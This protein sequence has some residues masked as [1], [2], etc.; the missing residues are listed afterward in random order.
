[1]TDRDWKE[2]LDAVYAKLEDPTAEK[3]AVLQSVEAIA[4]E[5]RLARAQRLWRTLPWTGY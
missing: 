4:A 3:E 1:M 5:W 2:L